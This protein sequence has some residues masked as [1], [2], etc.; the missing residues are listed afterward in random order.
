[1]PDIKSGSGSNRNAR[2]KIHTL[3][4]VGVFIALAYIF[5]FLFRFKASF[6]SFDLKDT[7]MTVGAMFFGPV[8]GLAMTV[9]VA[10]LEFITIGET[11]VYG[12]IM[13]IIS[14][15]TFV[16][17]ASIIYRY[18]RTF[19]GS[20]LAM[21][22]AVM[23]MTVM[24]IGANFVITPYYMHMKTE[25]VVPLIFSLILPFNLI[26]AIFNASMTFI[27]YKPVSIAL[28]QAGF[29]KPSDTGMMTAVPSSVAG[30][31]VY[32]YKIKWVS[33]V[34]PIIIAAAAMA[35]FFMVLKGSL[36]FK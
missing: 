24:M 25:E 34:I 8:Y 4:A 2:S 32:K 31:T 27:L 7:V 10:L 20:V 19:R 9:I 6:L 14:S 29:I 13:D 15:A 12:L 1:M 5:I 11:G 3:T 17:A 26:K 28:K 18:R 22:S 36:T 21:A 16:C 35:V 33:V 30:E 23:V